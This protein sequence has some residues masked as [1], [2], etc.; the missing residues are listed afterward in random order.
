MTSIDYMN[1]LKK[2][3]FLDFPILSFYAKNMHFSFSP[4]LAKTF[5]TISLTL[6]VA[7]LVD[8]V[9]RS[10]IRVPKHFDTRRSRTYATILRN[11]VTVIVYAIALH[12]IFLELG[13]NITPLLASAGIVGLAIGLGAKSLIEDFIG[14]LSLLSQ[15]SIVTGD[16][17]KIDDIEGSIENI[18][19]RTLTIRAE[20]GSLHII[21][22]GQ[23]K[24]VINFSRHRTR[25]FVTIPVKTDQKIELILKAFA[26]ALTA[27]EKDE[28][29]S[30]VLYDGSLVDGI[31]DFRPEGNYM[32]MRTTLVTPP[33]HRLI[34]G[35]EFRYLVKKTFEKYKI[36]LG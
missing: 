2:V 35:R 24:K 7:V 20:N 23:I 28:R 6:L 31:E 36:Q 18:G 10:L 32:V 22:N 15:D 9:L 1:D 29:F 34:I 4:Q 13:I 12:I 19:F 17:V 3:F 30:E 27:L 14:G 21:P 33:A 11:I 5:F 8:Q 26:E 16:I 25:F